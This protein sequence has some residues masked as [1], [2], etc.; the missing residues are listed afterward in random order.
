MNGYVSRRKCR[1]IIQSTKN[2]FDVMLFSAVENNI[3]HYVRIKKYF[4]KND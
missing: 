4:Q 1:R 3:S 2:M